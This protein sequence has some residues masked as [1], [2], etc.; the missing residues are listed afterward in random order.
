[1]K[2]ITIL[3][4]AAASCSLVS[5]DADRDYS[6]PIQSGIV[7]SGLVWEHPRGN[8]GS[9]TG[10]PIKKGCK[11]DIYDRVIVT[12]LNDGTKQVEEFSQITKLIIK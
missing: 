7:E 2:P 9:N 11:V 5:C 8:L 3:V 4:C 12:H 6:T 1:M 10:I